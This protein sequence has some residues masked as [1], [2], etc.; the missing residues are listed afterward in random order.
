MISD[1][2]AFQT[3]L[4]KGHTAIWD[5]DWEGAVGAYKQALLETPDHPQGLSGLGLAYFQLHKF[6]EAL[7]TYKRIS[8][9]KHD[10]PMPFEKIGRIYE[11]VGM[12]RDSIMCYLKAAEMQLSARDVDRA[13]G[14]LNDVT[15]LDPENQTAH[16]RLAMI[17]DKL[18]RKSEAVTEF[19]AVAALMQQ[20]GEP[21]RALQAA[22]Y[23]LHSLPGSPEAQNAVSLL[24][25]G[26]TLPLPERKKGGTGPVRMAQIRGYESSQNESAVKNDPIT[27]ARLAAL[28]EMAILLFEQSEDSRSIANQPG[29]GGMQTLSRVSGEL[30]PEQENQ[31]RIKVHLSQAIDL[32][33]TNQDGQASIELERSVDLGL[34]QIAAFFVLGLLLRE[35]DPNKALKHLQKSV[36]NTTYALASYILIANIYQNSGQLK[37]ASINYF[38]ALRLADAETVPQSEAEDLKQLYEPIFESQLHVND[39]KDLGNL[40][41]VINSQLSRS[42]WRTYLSA[43]RAQLPQQPAGSPPLPLAEM[44]ME[45]TSGQIVESIAFVRKLVSEKKYR[46]AMEEAYHALSYAPTYMPLHIQIGEILIAEGRIMEAVEKFLHVSRLY[47]IR[48]E[49]AQAIRLLYRVTKLAPMDISVRISLIDLLKSIGRIDDAIQQSIDLANVYYLLAELDLA[50]QTYHSALALARQSSSAREWSVKILNKL[51]D[52]ELQSLDL[53]QAIKVFEQLRS[54]QP[55]EPAPRLKLIDLYFRMGLGAAAMNELDAYLKLLEGDKQ[56]HTAEKFF[57]ILLKERPENTD[58]QKRMT[59][60]YISRGQTPKAIEKLD[61]LAEKQMES[62]QL[63]EALAIVQQIIGLNPPNRQDYEKLIAVLRERKATTP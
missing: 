43:A 30:S 7:K 32:L 50:R 13:I 41:N 24:K 33:T 60:Y 23:A 58:I 52:L 40:C 55:Y 46:T 62:G 63:S 38:Q 2:A 17:F 16:I 4:N 57:D 6:E 15:R 18:G 8:A 31:A 10:D 1:S 54:L 39:E 49:T 37:V 45:S 25:N 44:L 36:R 3:L 26:L 5:Q 35:K 20:T 47:T 56:S 22:Q 42:D 53:K 61:R 27:E 12:L 14:N 9:L 29:K 48:G 11:R 19:V 59:G 51:A 21:V 28:K 34:N